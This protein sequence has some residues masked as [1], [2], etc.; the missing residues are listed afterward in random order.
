MRSDTIS[1]AILG[2]SAMTVED[3]RI[4]LDVLEPAFDAFCQGRADD[5]QSRAVIGV[6]NV[7]V[8]LAGMPG[9][10]GG[11]PHE[12]TMLCS[13][14]LKT[15]AIRRS[16]GKKAL[17]AEEKEV[18]TA[19]LDLYK[20]VIENVAIRYIEEAEHRTEQRIA[21]ADGVYDLKRGQQVRR[22]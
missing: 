7:M 6:H 11:Q 21:R 1:L 5:E 9:V 16:E 14:T 15:I 12:F 13:D 3:Q 10:L 2:S 22:K 4:R 8:A 19:L 18:L 20:Q 17:Y